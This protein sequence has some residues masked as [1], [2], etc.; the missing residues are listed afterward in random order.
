MITWCEPASMCIILH[1][2]IDKVTKLD[3]ETLKLYFKLS[4]LLVYIKYP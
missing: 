3:S 4:Q 1:I 2:L